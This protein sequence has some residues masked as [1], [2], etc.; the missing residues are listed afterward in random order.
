MSYH[1]LLETYDPYYWDQEWHMING[2]MMQFLASSKAQQEVVRD[3][4]LNASV[5]LS[6]ANV[7]S[8]AGALAGN[9]GAVAGA[10]M[11]FMSLQANKLPTNKFGGLR[12][13][14][15]HYNGDIYVLD[16]K[17]WNEFSRKIIEGFK[18]KLANAKSINP[19]QMVKISE[20]I[21][22][23]AASNV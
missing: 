21:H 13:P 20:T 16:K 6:A 5:K 12:M 23:I 4:A 9:A 2:G 8:N 7:A 18:S 22:E 19:D 15:L 1:D 3:T 11:S 14:H 10:S 17:Q